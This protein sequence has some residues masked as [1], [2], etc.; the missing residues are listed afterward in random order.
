M[1]INENLDLLEIH[2]PRGDGEM[3]IYPTLLH[4]PGHLMLFDAGLPGSAPRIAE[5]ISQA[6]F[7]AAELTSIVLTHQDLDHI[8]GAA[9]LLKLAKN[10]KLYAPEGDADF[11]EG[12]QMPTKLAG[13]EAKKEAG[14]LPSG[15]EGFYQMLNQGFPLS[16]LPVDIRLKDGQSFD[17]AGGL[18]VVATPGHTPGHASYYLTALK[19]MIV[20]DAANIADG[21]LVGSNPPMT[22]DMAKADAS[23]EKIKSYDL[24]GIISYHTG[25][26]EF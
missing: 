24:K 10:A 25:Y 20:G 12:K 6:G 17:I 9:E 2:I 4:A 13:L 7:E 23:L 8:G 19:I 22:W 21:E 1:K 5:A 15:Q 16:Y 11:I 26:L 3:V 18:E 14:E